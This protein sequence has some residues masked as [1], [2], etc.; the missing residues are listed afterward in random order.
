[1]TGLTVRGCA[2]ARATS[3]GEPIHGSG[4]G[5]RPSPDSRSRVR[6]SG[7][8]APSRSEAMSAGVAPR[9]WASSSSTLMPQR[10]AAPSTLPA[11]VPSTRSTLAKRPP[12]PLLYGGQR[13]GHP[14]RAQD[15]A[16]A[17]HQ[18]HAGHVRPPQLVEAVTD[19]VREHVDVPHRVTVGIE[20]IEDAA[21]V[22]RDTDRHRLAL[23]QRD[24]RVHVPHPRPHRVQRELRPGHVGDD[25]VEHPRRHRAGQA[26][27]HA[28]HRRASPGRPGRSARW[29]RWPARCP[30]APPSPR[31]PS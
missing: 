29:P 17:Q 31:T 26:R 13:P 15:P 11:L 14:R 30:C 25:H 18:P 9:W 8:S 16:C 6:M 27:T 20:S 5:G 10:S 24:H 3:R 7:R 22:A 1:M 21:V 19:R 12:D 4:S 2:T 23:R 28:V